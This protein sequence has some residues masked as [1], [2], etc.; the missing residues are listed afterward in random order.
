MF[1][2]G[3][4]FKNK[5]KLTALRREMDSRPGF[6]WMI[7]SDEVETFLLRLETLAVGQDRGIET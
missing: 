6:L 1:S 4:I 5:I 7:N 2:A 3:F